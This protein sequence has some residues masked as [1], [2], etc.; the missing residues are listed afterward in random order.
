VEKFSLTP[1]ANHG[2]EP[3]KPNGFRRGQNCGLIRLIVFVT[4]GQPAHCRAAFPRLCNPTQQVACLRTDSL[5]GGQLCP[6]RSSVQ[7][8]SLVERSPV[9]SR[10]NSIRSL[11]W[12]VGVTPITR[13]R[14]CCP[15]RSKLLQVT[16]A[17]PK[18]QRYRGSAIA[19]SDCRC[20][21]RETR[22]RLPRIDRRNNASTCVSILRGTGL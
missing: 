21:N 17:A 15:L 11:G 14:N 22:R 9:N 5:R 19:T 20:F 6:F 10:C 7:R 12:F 3:R 13:R 4:C 16:F 18:R 2:G 8:G 1:R